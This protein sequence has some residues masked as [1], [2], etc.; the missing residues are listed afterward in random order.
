MK[1]APMI[2][3]FDTTDFNPELILSSVFLDHGLDFVTNIDDLGDNIIASDLLQ[4]LGSSV[5]YTETPIATNVNGSGGLG[6]CGATTVQPHG[7][8]QQPQQQHH[9]QQMLSQPPPALLSAKARMT[10]ETLSKKKKQHQKNLYD[11]VC[12]I[13]S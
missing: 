3:A 4:Q 1:E 2:D 8:N 10:N 13:G 11:C 5:F 9:Q 6:L 12:V 7:Q